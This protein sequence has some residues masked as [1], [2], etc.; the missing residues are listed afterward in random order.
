[1]NVKKYIDKAILIFKKWGFS[2]LLLIPIWISIERAWV[3][4]SHNILLAVNYPYPPVLN[5]I[6]FIIDT[7]DLLLHEGGHTI[8]GLFGWRFLTILGGS[9]MAVLI[10]F[11]LFLTAW[12]KKQKVLAQACLFQMGYS[13][14]VSAIYCADAYYRVL[15]L[16]GN[17]ESKEGHDYANML[18]ALN[19]VH[20]NMEV[21]WVIFS[22]GVLFL[23]LSFIWPIFERKELET[24]DLS[25]ELKKSGLR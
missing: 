18:G 19:I 20:K 10:P 13:I 11:L 8:F 6:F 3:S 24:I 2:L 25:K 9:L 22:F 12:D 1:M 7:L 16:I 5:F 4:I 17:D 15:P 14:F 21:A 23:I